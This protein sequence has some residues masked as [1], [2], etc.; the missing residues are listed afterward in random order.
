MIIQKNDI[1]TIIKN[2]FVFVEIN[3]KEDFEQKYNKVTDIIND[4][5]RQTFGMKKNKLI[6]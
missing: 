5:F 1:Y 2:Y 3:S 4:L 6:I